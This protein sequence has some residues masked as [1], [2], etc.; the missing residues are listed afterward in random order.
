MKKIEWEIALKTISESNTTEHW[1][2]SSK[3]HRQQQFF[4]RELFKNETAEIPIPCVVKMTRLGP[5]FLDADDNLRMAFKWIKDEISECVFPE[6][7]GTYI[8]KKGKVR[9]IKGRADDSPLIVWEY[10]QEKSK[11]LGVRIEIRDMN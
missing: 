7:C 4:I 2:K 10:A 9:Q 11:S 8:D 3:R 1:T 6:K 5:R